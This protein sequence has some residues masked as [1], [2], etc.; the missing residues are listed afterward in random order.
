MWTKKD[1][2]KNEQKTFGKQF[3]KFY[4]LEILKSNEKKSLI[5]FLE[6]GIN[7]HSHS[8]ERVQHQMIKYTLNLSPTL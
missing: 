3:A 5:N 8:N 7:V 4:M 2:K 1:K 6:S